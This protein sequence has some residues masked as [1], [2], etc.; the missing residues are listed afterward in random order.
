MNKL[1][2][3]LLCLVLGP[4]VYAQTPV[5]LEILQKSRAECLKIR[6]G[7]YELTQY[8]KFI[9]Q[10][11]TMVISERCYFRKMPAD[12]IYG[13]A[14]HYQRMRGKTDFGEVMYSGEDLISTN[15]ADSTAEIIS[16]SKSGKYLESIK[17][18]H[19][20]N[21]Y[22]PFYIKTCF[23]FMNEKGLIKDEFDVQKAGDA[24]LNG[25][26]CYRIIARQKPGTFNTAFF[27]PLRQ[28]YEYWIDKHTFL[29]LQYTDLSIALINNDT[30]EQFFRFQLNH[31][32]INNQKN[33]RELSLNSIPTYYK[34]KTFEEVKAPPPLSKG[35]LAPLWTLVSLNNDTVKLSD[36]KG[37]PVLL[38]FFYKSC[39]PC[40]LALPKLQA[41]YEK[42]RDE[43][44]VVIGIDPVDKKKDE[45]RAFLAKKGVAYKILLSDE[46]IPKA[47]HVSG[48]P[49]ICLLDA[50]GK[51][52]FSLTGFGQGI[53][54]YLDMMIK[55]SLYE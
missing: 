38:D 20:F 49:M 34:L 6:N 44:L 40:M 25:I 5:A 10:T 4:G 50:G 52:V 29:P 37:K 15:P 36:L 35:T 45:L 53:E 16:V 33:E 18:N 26:E 8:L 1:I 24:M 55:K 7:N 12:T 14:F 43:G 48:Y 46:N 42:Y 31:V 22:Q 32:D 13:W 51:I 19:S 41:L 11:D 54:D 9:G 39:Y 30:T 17:Q 3:F 47:Y 28:D 2:I 27:I 21:L 23:P